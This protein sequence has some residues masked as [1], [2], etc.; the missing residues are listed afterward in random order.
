MAIDLTADPRTDPEIQ[1]L[2]GADQVEIYQSPA[3][4]SEWPIQ[5]WCRAMGDENPVYTD[6]AAARSYGHED[7]FAPPVMMYS[8][9]MPG[10]ST[11]TRHEGLLATLRGRMSKHGFDSVLAGSYEQEFITPVRLGDRLRREAR[12]ESMSDRKIT[13]VGAGYFVMLADRIVNQKG[14]WVGNQKMRTLFFRPGP[15]D[16]THQSGE[17]RKSA[18]TRK[19][20]EPGPASA[21]RV[22]LPPLAIPVTT[23]LVIAAALA[24]NDFEKIHHDRDLAR[25]QGLSDISMNVLTWCGLAIRYVTDWAGPAARIRRISTQLKAPTYPGDTLTLSGWTESSFERGIATQV[26]VRGANSLK[27]HIDSTITIS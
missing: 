10:L 23:T 4:V 11:E 14:E 8:F 6:R 13:S 7:V 15:A 3:P 25:S 17:T 1:A 21:T 9:T 26:H 2:F 12:F 18:E 24:T 22:E 20:L 5:A 16:E 19:A 27:A